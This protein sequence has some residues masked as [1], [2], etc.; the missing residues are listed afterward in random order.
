MTR[1]C[2]SSENPEEPREN[3]ILRRALM[4][5]DA[6]VESLAVRLR[7]MANKLSRAERDERLALS[8]LLHDHIQPLVVGARMQLWELQRR[9][10]NPEVGQISTKIEGILVEALGA[11]RSLSVELSPAALQNNGLKGGL[12]FLRTYMTDKFQ[13]TV[14]L[15]IYD[16]IDPIE[17]ET[18]F[19]LY[20][21]VKEL[22][23]NTVKHAG[24]DSADIYVQRT[25]EHLIS[26]VVEDQGKGFDTGIIEQPQSENATLGLFSIQER[27]AAID[28]R[29]IIEAAVDGGT[30]VTLTAPAGPFLSEDENG[31]EGQT[32]QKE[33]VQVRKKE[34][35]IGILIVDDHSVMRQG[36]RGLL[37]TEP[38]FT[39]LGEAGSGAK[40]IEMALE[41]DPDVILMDINLGDMSGMDATRRILS[42]QPDIRVIGLSMYEDEGFGQAMR[43]AGACGYLTKHASSDLI[44]AS[45]RKAAQIN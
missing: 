35:G 4:E 12:N 19:L 16:E 8:A 10:K 25:S 37:Q 15:T 43:K 21:G 11:L 6:Q 41:H 26:L 39:V 20:E 44:I 29:M 40:G 22:L 36:L 9:N 31:A 24:V 28:G 32:L 17:E 7:R 45:V 13:F 42:R 5:K 27:L 2:F 18:S 1:P 33:A 34:K 30:R 38:D 14:N 23:L 3:R